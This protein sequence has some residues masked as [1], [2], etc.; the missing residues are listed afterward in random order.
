MLQCNCHRQLISSVSYRLNTD[1]PPV[2]SVD[3][4]TYGQHVVV[5]EQNVTENA[6]SMFSDEI[7]QCVVDIVSM[8]L[9]LYYVYKIYPS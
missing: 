6:E 8:H 3:N 7:Q 9:I 1:S 2:G 5:T 4:Q